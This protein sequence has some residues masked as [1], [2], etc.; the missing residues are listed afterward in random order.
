MDRTAE[1]AE[2]C[3]LISKPSRIHV[4]VKL[5]TVIKLVAGGRL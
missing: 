4:A 2:C 1:T 5:C 3:D